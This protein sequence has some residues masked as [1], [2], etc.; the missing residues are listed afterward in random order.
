[1]QYYNAAL[2]DNGSQT[3][4]LTNVYFTGTPGAFELNCWGG[5]YALFDLSTG[6]VQ[7]NYGTFDGNFGTS[8]TGI[9]Q[10]GPYWDQVQYWTANVWGC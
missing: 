8:T 9:Y 1:M 3:Y 6:V 7:Y 5:Y 4:Y 2:T 10:D